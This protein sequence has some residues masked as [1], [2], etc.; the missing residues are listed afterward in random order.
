MGRA[1]YF[2]DTF[3]KIDL[4]VTLLDLASIALE[5]VVQ[6]GENLGFASAFRALR[7][8]RFVRFVRVFRLARYA[9]RGV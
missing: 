2:A 5:G 8:I 3:C 6:G 1:D 9:K 7:I 4:A